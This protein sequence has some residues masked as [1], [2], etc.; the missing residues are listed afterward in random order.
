MLLRVM[1]LIFFGFAAQTAYAWGSEG[2]ALVADIAEANL[3]VKAKQQIQALLALEGYSHLEE[4]ASWADHSPPRDAQTSPW[5]YV[6][7]P[8]AASQFDEQRDCLNHNCVIGKIADFAH[9]LADKNLDQNQRLQ[10]LKWLVHF[11]GDL[12][13]PLHAANNNDHGGNDVKLHYFARET[14]FHKLWDT[15]ILEQALNLHESGNFNF[16]HAAVLQAAQQQMQL[17]AK[18]K[19]DNWL[20]TDSLPIIYGIAENWAMESHAFAEQAYQAL[21]AKTKKAGWEKAYQRKAWPI[22]QLRL[23]QAGIRL[24]GLLNDSVSIE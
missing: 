13:V 21:P 6:A 17:L 12:H 15:T 10:A 14:N 1:L 3:T 9:Q 16:D 11:V 20:V 24:A 8:L 4:V 18:T 22:V 23:Q 7:I 5:H 2:H 19:H